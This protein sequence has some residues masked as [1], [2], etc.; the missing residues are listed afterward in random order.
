MASNSEA[1]L[2]GQVE[3]QRSLGAWEKA[4]ARFL[5]GLDDAE[6]AT[7]TEATAENI[8]YAASNVQR[9]DHRDSKTRSLLESM[10]PL[11]SAV[12]DYGK[13]MDAFANIS[14]LYLAPIWGSIRVVLVI[15]S[16]HGRFY[17][18]MVDT[19]G[20]IGDILPRFRK[21]AADPW[22]RSDCTEENILGDYQRIFDSKKHQRFTQALS[23]AYLDIISLCT[24]FKTLLRNQK[25]SAAKRIFQ[26]LSPTLKEHLE[27]AIVRFRKHRK[28]VDKE[29]ELCHMIEEKEARD[30]VVRN[31]AAAEA[32]ERR[33]HAP[34]NLEAFVADGF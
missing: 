6:K 2:L 15:A 14:S 4:K 8:F 1:A 33:E 25:K 26:P 11:I 29:A 20:R 23:V 28:V 13:A 31:H 12:G 32:R 27:D 30:L 19:F 10:Q 7:F 9:D 21:C 24:E 3:P 17:N 5:E 22:R 16:S 34:H 18:R